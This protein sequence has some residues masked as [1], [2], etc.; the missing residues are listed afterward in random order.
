MVEG[1]DERLILAGGYRR[2]AQWRAVA[3]GAVVALAVAENGREVTVCGVRGKPWPG[4]RWLRSTIDGYGFWLGRRLNWFDFE[5][6]WVK[7]I[8]FS[9]Y[10]DQVFQRITE[11][12]N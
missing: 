9:I 5:H 8:R 1:D 7:L 2:R 10:R 12:H 6:I 3:S 11:H 4:E